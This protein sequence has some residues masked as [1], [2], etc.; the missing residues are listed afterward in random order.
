MIEFIFN[1]SKSNLNFFLKKNLFPIGIEFIVFHFFIFYY[2]NIISKFVYPSARDKL[3]RK[4]GYSEGQLNEFD[5][6]D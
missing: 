4:G 1:N 5:Y 3:S 2:T 6:Q